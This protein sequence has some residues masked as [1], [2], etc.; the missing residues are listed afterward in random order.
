MAKEQK[1]IIKSVSKK[2]SKKAVC[3]NAVA[4]QE[5]MIETNHSS[6]F[7]SF[8]PKSSPFI[9]FPCR[10]SHR[11]ARF[12]YQKYLCKQIHKEARSLEKQCMH[13][14]SLHAYNRCK[15]KE[16]RKK[17]IKDRAISGVLS[18]WLHA[19]SGVASY[20]KYKWKC[21]FFT[22]DATKEKKDQINN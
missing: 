3:G 22:D 20:K 8:T 5:M 16:S 12:A 4:H 13:D 18:L 1:A 17:V 11:F 15:E 6:H 21:Y 10:I 7:R 14:R 19:K 9:T 2:F